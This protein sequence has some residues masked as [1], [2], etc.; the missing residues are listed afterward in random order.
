MLQ[1]VHRSNYKRP[2]FHMNSCKYPKT[3]WSHTTMNCRKT[4]HKSTPRYIHHQYNK[5]NNICTHMFE[6]QAFIPMSLL[7]TKQS[8]SQ[9]VKRPGRVK[10]CCAQQ[11]PTGCVQPIVLDNNHA[12]SFT[13]PSTQQS[14]Q[15]CHQETD[16]GNTML[17]QVDLKGR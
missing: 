16:L 7:E 3:Q 6:Q 4:A 10:L 2:P 14:D 1:T 11:T 15:M 9:G 12:R 5:P 13:T 8:V 17:R